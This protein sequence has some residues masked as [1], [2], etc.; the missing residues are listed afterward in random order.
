VSEVSRQ[1]QKHGDVCGGR[2]QQDG[3]QRDDH[4]FQH[5]QQPGQ[6]GHDRLQR[7]RAVRLRLPSSVTVQDRRRGDLRR[8]GAAGIGEWKCA[9]INDFTGRVKPTVSIQR[10]KKRSRNRERPHQRG[11]ASGGRQPPCLRSA[12]ANVGRAS[13]EREASPPVRDQRS[14]TWDARRERV[15][16]NGLSEC[17]VESPTHLRGFDEI[18]R[19]V[20]K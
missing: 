11:G 10:P 16:R 5:Q 6:Q 19:V 17:A 18:C 2:H 1:H 20:E 4:Q 9:I 14:S 12:V 3:R 8:D 7:H 13:C 15:V